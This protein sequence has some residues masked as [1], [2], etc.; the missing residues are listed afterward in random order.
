[1]TQLELDIEPPLLA[2]FPSRSRG[3]PTHPPTCHRQTAAAPMPPPGIV[4]CPL[5][6]P[7]LQSVCPAAQMLTRPAPEQGRKIRTA[8]P[9]VGSVGPEANWGGAEGTY[10]PPRSHVA[11]HQ[12]EGF[13]RGLPGVG[14]NVNG[15]Q[16]PKCKKIRSLCMWLLGRG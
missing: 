3:A 2:L 9:G 1:M 16:G 14:S 13:E 7:M 5:P 6:C 4:R 8:V 12:G 15:Q 10:Y 11:A